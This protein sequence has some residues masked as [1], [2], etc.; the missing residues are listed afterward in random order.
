MSLAQSPFVHTHRRHPSAPPAPVVVQPT[1]TPG[2]LSL[3]RPKQHRP[4]PKPSPKPRHAQA[5]TRS[6]RPAPA[7]ATT[8]LKAAAE[9]R[10]RQQQGKK[11]QQQPQQRSASQ[12]APSRRR[13]PS[14][15]PFKAS[16]NPSPAPPK[17][18]RQQ[19]PIPVRPKLAP[20]PSAG[21]LS[22]SDPVL[23]HMPRRRLP[24]PQ[25]SATLDSDAFPIC[26]DMTDA[27][28]SRPGT[29][30]PAA[31]AASARPRTPP[32]TKRERPALT[33]PAE[34]RTPPRRRLPEPPRTAPLAAPAA[35][36]PF[37]VTTATGANTS[38]KRRPARAKHLS[39]GV[40]L[41]L[42]FPAEAA[43]VPPAPGRARSS[44]RLRAE[45]QALFASSMFQ[46]SP[47][48]EEL[49]PPLFA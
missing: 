9:I 23:S 14:P 49:P 27:G 5:A 25:R 15:D 48:P 17:Q 2:L 42:L 38:P 41:P 44:E 20:N 7:E 1:R 12:A 46:N 6:P 19:Q 21:A 29:P 40:L 28:A 33:L 4:D 11:Q 3:S 24:L 26:D 45:A 32:S 16:P 31:A 36:F 37:P 10:G 13:Q 8:P 39:E 47:S 22:S 30:T 35:F 18:P 43:P 34:P